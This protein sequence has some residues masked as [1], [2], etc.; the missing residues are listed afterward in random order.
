[1]INLCCCS[2][3]PCGMWIRTKSDQMRRLWDESRGGRRGCRWNQV[4]GNGSG[5]VGCLSGQLVSQSHSTR[6]HNWKGQRLK[7]GKWLIFE[8]S[9]VSWVFL[10]VCQHKTHVYEDKIVFMLLEKKSKQCFFFFSYVWKPLMKKLLCLKG[11]GGWSSITLRCKRTFQQVFPF[12]VQCLDGLNIVSFV[13]K[14]DFHINRK[15]Q[16]GE[17]WEHLILHNLL[18][19]N[20]TRN[21][22]SETILWRYEVLCS[23]HI[24]HEWSGTVLQRGH[25]L[26]YLHYLKISL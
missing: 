6:S 16:R 15:Q 10:R 24:V 2:S 13:L 19:T 8:K 17:I 20:E 1:M 21:I 4:V 5:G 23:I 26:Y 3:F 9:V 18:M 7:S 22:H 14:L 25:V 12:S 11:L